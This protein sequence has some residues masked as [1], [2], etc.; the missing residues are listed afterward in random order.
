MRIV[1]CGS[2]EVGAVAL[3]ALCAAGA[4]IRLV[5]TQPPRKAGRG[6]KL[7]PTPVA[8][9]E[10]DLRIATWPCEDINTDD[11]AAMIAAARPE[12]IV[13]VD[14]G[15]KIGEPVRQLAAHGAINM[16]ASLLPALR[17]AAPINWA[18][19][20]GMT[21]TGVTTFRLVDKMDAG[22]ILLQE[23]VAIEPTETA[24]DL[25]ERLA[26]AGGELVVRTIDGLAAGTI[27]DTPQDEQ[28]VS[29]APKLTKQDGAIDFAAGGVETVNRIRGTWPWPGGHA[30]FIGQGRK[31]VRVIFAGARAMLTGEP[32]SAEPG[33]VAA[34][35]TINVADGA[36][37]ILQLKVAGK[38]LMGWRDFVNGYRVAEG[39]RFVGPGGGGNG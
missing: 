1:F 19:I 11:G 9:R 34:D 30:D 22:P 29:H 28:A 18:I 8:K 5:L 7:A 38:R 13:V 16:H 15:Q 3:E 12:L 36:V 32:N 10:D 24:E 23:P 14:F 37:E 4:D 27:T 21:E 39:D 2:G 31:P 25:R 20:R 33:T 35:L 26:A 17:G 6:G